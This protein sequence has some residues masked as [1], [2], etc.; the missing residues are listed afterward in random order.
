M[1]SLFH[2]EEKHNIFRNLELKVFLVAK[3]SKTLISNKTCLVCKICGMF[4]NHE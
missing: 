1:I 4:M 2:R 3:S